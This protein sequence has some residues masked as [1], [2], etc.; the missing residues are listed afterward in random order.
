MEKEKINNNGY[1]YVD[2]E[3]P[4]GTLWAA[5]NV[6]ADSSSDYG[7]Y[8]QWGDIKGY[9]KE[10]VGKD[11]LFN[12][13]RYKWIN[14]N[15]GTFT[16]YTATKASLEL[17]DDAAHVHMKGDWHIPTPE[18]VQELIDNTTKESIEQ[19]GVK[20]MKFTSKNDTSKYIFIPMSGEAWDGVVGYDGLCGYIWS[21]MVSSLTND[22]GQYLYF[23]LWEP[24]LYYGHERWLGMPI[25]GVIG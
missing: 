12:W 11:K 19:N 15:N 22:Y 16:K 17:E 4:S 14:V 3:L 2:L 1:E 10:Q 8:F 21:S 18:Q 9:T 5:C 13:D 6:G 7:L 20:G 23:D 25:R 24:K